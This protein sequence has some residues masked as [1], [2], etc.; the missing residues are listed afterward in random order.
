MGVLGVLAGSGMGYGDQQ[1]IKGG[2][3]M[4]GTGG[5]DGQVG[6]GAGGGGFWVPEG[7]GRIREAHVVFE[8]LGG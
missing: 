2:K 8:G 4:A 3:S 1:G 6:S 5:L 7:F